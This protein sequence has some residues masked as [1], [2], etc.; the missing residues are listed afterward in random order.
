MYA[1]VILACMGAVCQNFIGREVLTSQE[2]CSQEYLKGSFILRENNPG[3]E[4]LDAQCINWD[5]G[6]RTP[7]ME[8][9]P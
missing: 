5:T 9:K 8:E 2:A 7:M 3:V 4:I 6:E 1:L